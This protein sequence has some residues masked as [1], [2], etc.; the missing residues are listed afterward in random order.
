MSLEKTSAYLVSLNARRE[1]DKAAAEAVNKTLW[2]SRRYCL[3]V[4]AAAKNGSSG[5][6]LLKLERVLAAFGATEDEFLRDVEET[7]QAMA[8][9]ALPATSPEPAPAAPDA[10]AAQPAT[11]RSVSQPN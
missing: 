2:A 3:M 6:D 8:G 11:V 9:T 5:I 4:T 10:D 7:Y 1:A